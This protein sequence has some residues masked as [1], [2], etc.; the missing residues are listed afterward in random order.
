ME[1]IDRLKVTSDK[2]IHV[3]VIVV[4]ECDGLDG[5]HVPVKPRL[6][7]YIAKNSIPKVLVKNAMAEPDYKEIGQ[8]VIVVIEP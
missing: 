7:G 1:D 6:F 4:V 3:A 5:I 2:Q 8:A